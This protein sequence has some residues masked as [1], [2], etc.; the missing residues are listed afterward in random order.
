MLLLSLLQ[1]MSALPEGELRGYALR[2]EFILHLWKSTWFKR[3]ARF[4]FPI[5]LGIVWWVSG[6]KLLSPKR[7]RSYVQHTPPNSYI[8]VL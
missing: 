4:V 5:Q 3:Q 2:L 1:L 6:L 7:V 8:P